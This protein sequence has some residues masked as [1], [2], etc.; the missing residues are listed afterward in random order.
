MCYNIIYNS[1]YIYY[2]Y[3]LDVVRWKWLHMCYNIIY[4]SYYIYLLDA[5][6][7]K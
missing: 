6:S 7:L 5:I 3:L 2:I 1:Y 4:N